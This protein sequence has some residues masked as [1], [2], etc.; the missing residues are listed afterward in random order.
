MI[1]Y[2]TLGGRTGELFHAIL[3]DHDGQAPHVT[4]NATLFDVDK[5]TFEEIMLDKNYL[6]VGGNFKREDKQWN[7]LSSTYEL[8]FAKK[9]TF[10]YPLCLTKVLREMDVLR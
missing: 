3:I 5:N 6:F 8:N 1:P 4:I 9:G 7:I 2:T 10:V